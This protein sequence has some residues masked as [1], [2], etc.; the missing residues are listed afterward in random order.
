MSFSVKVTN[1]QQNPMLNIC[2]SDLLDRTVE[3]GKRKV[4]INKRY[5]GEKTVEEDEAQHL[6]KTSSIINMAGTKTVSLSIRIG[7]GIES[8][9][10]YVD[11]VPFLIVLQS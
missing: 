9:V 3:D 10:K 8:G 1:Y 11:T 5:Y 4:T 2:D 7:V 6:L